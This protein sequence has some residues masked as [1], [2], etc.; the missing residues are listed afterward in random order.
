MMQAVKYSVRFAA[1]VLGLAI[2]VVAFR[3]ADPTNRPYQSALS[4]L[5]ISTYAFAG[6][7]P[8]KT[9]MKAS[10]VPTNTHTSCFLPMTGGCIVSSC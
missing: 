6:S 10:C 9:C 7:C 3:P 5:A 2:V 4:N 8:R 1:I